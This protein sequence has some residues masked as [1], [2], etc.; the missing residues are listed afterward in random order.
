MNA[1]QRRSAVKETLLQ[2]DFPLSAGTLAARF[3]VS[4]QIIV[5]DVALLRAEGCPI[6]ATPRGYLVQHETHLATRTVACRHT[7]DELLDELYTIVDTGCGILDVIVEHPVYGQLTG[8]LSIASRYDADEFWNLL[9][10]QQAEPLSL[11]T[12]D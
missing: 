7:R 5:G 6:I 10:E 3:G 11:L 2:S 4:R 1:T 8:N 9:V 12:G